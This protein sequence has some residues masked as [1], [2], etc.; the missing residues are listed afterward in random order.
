MKKRFFYILIILCSVK[1]V[2]AQNNTSPYSMLGIGD[3]ENSY[4]DRTTGMANT[5]LAMASNRFLYQGNPASYSY[6]DDKIFNVEVASRFKSIVYSGQPVVNTA[7]NTSTDLQFKKFVLAMKLKPRWGISLGLLPFSTQNYSFY[8]TKII[9]GT[10]TSV[11]AYNEGYGST[12]QFYLANSYRVSRHLSV[13]VQ[14]AWLFGQLQQKETIPA[15]AINDS[16]IVTN[17]NIFL[18]N[19]YFTYGLQYHTKI[20][21]NWDFS[22]GATAALKTKLRANYTL[23]VQ[24]G[25]TYII[26]NQQYQNYYFT[27]PQTYNAGVAAVLKNKFTFAADYGFQN[28]STLNY[29]GYNYSLTNSSKIS[30]GFEYSNKIKARDFLY[31]KYFLQAGLYYSTSYLQVYGQN[32]SD[33]GFTIGAGGSLPRAPNLSLLAAFQVGSRGTTAEGLVKENYT[34]FN[35]TISFREFW[36]VKLKHYD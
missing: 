3:L 31:E 27:I 18:G 13:G 1:G 17:S 24:E 33:Y 12:N 10:T 9:N 16:A 36:Y 35:I 34:Q 2:N 6:L 14:A 4:F 29:K 26:N 7:T 21:K 32:I 30:T 22:F 15:T 28:W 19:L 20:N 25:T 23:Q 5:G 11:N 8:G